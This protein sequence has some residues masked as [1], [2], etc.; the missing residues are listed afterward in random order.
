MPRN[1]LECKAAANSRT[2]APARKFKRRSL[3]ASVIPATAEFRVSTPATDASTCTLGDTRRR[4]KDGAQIPL[5]T[6]AGAPVANL[7]QA[8]AAA[9]AFAALSNDEKERLLTFLNSL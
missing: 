7:V 3:W 6:P 5:L 2:Q 1:N 8:K 4:A 9:D